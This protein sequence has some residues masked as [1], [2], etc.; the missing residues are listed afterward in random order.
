MNGMI[1]ALTERTIREQVALGRDPLYLYDTAMIRGMCRRFASLP[2][3]HTA[4][5]FACMANSHPAFLGIIREE[6]LG[7]FVNSPMHLHLALAAGFAG[8]E[9]VYA[10]SAM[11]EAAMWA[12]H[13]AGAIVNLDSTDQVARWRRMFPES[14][15][16]IRCN[17]GELVEPRETRGGY[18]IGRESRLG[19]TPDEIH[20]LRGDRSVAGLHLYVGTDICSLDYFRRCYEV[21]AEF[22]AGFPAVTHLDLGGGFGLEDEQGEEFDFGAYGAMTAAFMRRVSA[23]AGRPVRMI[24]EPGRIIGGRAGWFVCRVTDVK[25]RGGRQ[26]VGVNA[27]SVQFPRPLFYPDSA[28]H[29]VRIL[30]VDN[31][32][33][34]KPALRSSVYGCS[35][36]SRDFLAR[37]VQLPNA[38]IGDIVV[39]GNAGSYCASAYTRFLGF[40]PAKEVFHDAAT[41]SYPGRAADVSLR[42]AYGL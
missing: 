1:S 19:L 4:V 35:T 25:L 14:P 33:N 27:S 21:L 42:A 28:R 12:V 7:I 37:D 38:R 9:I 17:I 32:L 39:L 5:H 29:P 26:L 13:D 6:G 10:A 34:G 2:Y 15:F 8:H 11:D 30:H 31:A 23:A 40:P 36:Y 22:A 20:A 41:G 3:P 24:L 18:F 16:G